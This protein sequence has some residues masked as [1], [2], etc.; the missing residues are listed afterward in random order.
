ML[1]AAPKYLMNFMDCKT[2]EDKINVALF[3]EFEMQG[4]IAVIE[5]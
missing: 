2:N 5:K 3:C 1:F 4:N